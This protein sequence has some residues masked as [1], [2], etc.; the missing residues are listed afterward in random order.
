ML[1]V[2]EP[3][4]AI[5]LPGAWRSML[6]SREQEVAS[7]VLRGWDNRLIATELG[8]ETET[9]KKHLYRVYDKLGVETRAV[10]I[11]RAVEQNGRQ[12]T[13]SSA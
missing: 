1:V 5:P 4:E 9:V 11:A 12:P 10:L 7:A 13:P 3:L 8:C 2:E 6:T